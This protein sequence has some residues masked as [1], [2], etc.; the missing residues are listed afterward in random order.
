[1]IWTKAHV[2]KTATYG[3]PRLSVFFV[4]RNI[5]PNMPSSDM[6]YK[7]REA[8]IKHDNAAEND[9]RMMPMKMMGGQNEIG[10]KKV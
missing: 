1:M 8:P 2:T 3:L 10:C 6:A 5:G 9:E 7:T 4:K